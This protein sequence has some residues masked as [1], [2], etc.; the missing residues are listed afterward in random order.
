MVYS[1]FPRRCGR[2]IVYDCKSKEAGWRLPGHVCA[3]I[4]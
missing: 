1:Y 3:F 4:T 2:T